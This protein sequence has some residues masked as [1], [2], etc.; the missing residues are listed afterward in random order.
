IIAALNDLGEQHQQQL[1]RV[2]GEIVAGGTLT[3]G[4]LASNNVKVQIIQD[5]EELLDAVLRSAASY[6]R[7]PVEEHIQE[8]IEASYKGATRFENAVIDAFRSLRLVAR[9]IGGPGKTDGTVEIPITG[10]KNLSIC[11]EAKGTKGIIS[12]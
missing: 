1:H 7:D 2:M 10:D 4:L 3:E 5:V 11:I 12:H 6:I 8:I 9:H